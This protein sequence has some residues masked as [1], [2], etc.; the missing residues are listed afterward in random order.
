MESR[1]RDIAAAV[2]GSWLRLDVADRGPGVPAG[3]EGRLFEKFYRAPSA[4][5]RPG[6]NGLSVESVDGSTRLTA[7]ELA[8]L[9]VAPVERLAE[10]GAG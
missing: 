2:E 6:A 8:P 3:E 7:F 10:R 1:V 9:A 5:G 4:F